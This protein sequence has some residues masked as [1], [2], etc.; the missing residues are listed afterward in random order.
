MSTITLSRH[1]TGN[2]IGNR[3]GTG[4]ANEIIKAGMFNV[5]QFCNW[6]TGFKTD[7]TSKSSELPVN[8]YKEKRVV[9]KRYF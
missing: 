1:R 5:N 3:K 4:A 6:V 8:S 7:E 9:A 2:M